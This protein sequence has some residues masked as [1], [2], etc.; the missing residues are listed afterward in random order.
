MKLPIAYYGDPILRKKAAPITEI[1]DEIRQLVPDMLETMEAN[2]GCGLAAPQ[3]H[4]SIA[5]FITSV[6]RY[7]KDDNLIPGPLRVFINPKITGYSQEVWSLDEGCISIPKLRAEVVRP[8]KITIEATDLEGNV[9]TE[10][11]VHFE[12]RL[13]MHENDHLNGVLYIDRLSPRERK[14]IERDLR[15][16]KKKYHK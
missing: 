5:L 1:T 12:A 11:F 15:E 16:I 14:E 10:E 4:K 2:D 9:F 6:P 7:D 13:F 8:L 3:I